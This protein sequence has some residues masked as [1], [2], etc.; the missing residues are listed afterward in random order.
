MKRIL[1]IFFFITALF[2]SGCYKATQ[3]SVASNSTSNIS[4]QKSMDSFTS[5]SNQSNNS[6]SSASTAIVQGKFL[7]IDVGLE[8]VIA[9][10]SDGSVWTWGSNSNG[11]LGIGKEE[12]SG[13]TTFNELNIRRTPVKIIDSGIKNVYAGLQFSM[14]LKEDGTVMAWGDNHL[15]QLGIKTKDYIYTPVKIPIQNVKDIAAGVNDTFFIKEDGSLW[16]CGYNEYGELGD[17]TTTFRNEPIKIIESGVKSVSTDYHHTMVAKTD[18]SLWGCGD[19]SYGQLGD[20][21]EQI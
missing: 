7:K 9:L 8:H 2:L 12:S 21:V 16:G 6:K 1:F 18:G 4:S 10:A 19:R 13:K 20:G 14:A 11:E 3:N 17:G 5:Q 15:G